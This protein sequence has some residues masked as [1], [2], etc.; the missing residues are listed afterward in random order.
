MSFL[1]RRR[2]FQ[3]V[4]K[5]NISDLNLIPITLKNRLKNTITTTCLNTGKIAISQ[6]QYLNSQVSALELDM[7]FACQPVIRKRKNYWRLCIQVDDFD[8]PITKEYIVIDLIYQGNSNF[9][10]TYG[11]LCN[12][13]YDEYKSLSETSS[14]GCL[15]LFGFFRSGNVIYSK[16]CSVF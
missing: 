5:D 4:L 11:H 15:G 13:V 14:V 1:I 8:N 10:L 3:G 7:N 6:Y 16:I 2:V 9:P 12:L